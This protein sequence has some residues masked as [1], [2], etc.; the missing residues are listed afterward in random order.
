MDMV[1]GKCILEGDCF[2]GEVITE[3][4]DERSSLVGVEE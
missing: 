2:S 4:R 3:L 1:L